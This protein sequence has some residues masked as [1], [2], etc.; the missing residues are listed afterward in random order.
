MALMRNHGLLLCLSG[1][2]LGT[3]LK[4]TGWRP[5]VAVYCNNCFLV[6]DPIVLSGSTFWL[7]KLEAN[8]GVILIFF[9]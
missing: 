3:V 1:L 7:N 6:T 4:C 8:V 5:A 2:W 9:K